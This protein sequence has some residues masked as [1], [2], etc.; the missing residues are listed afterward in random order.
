MISKTNCNWLTPVITAL[1]LAGVIP[2]FPAQ[3]QVSWQQLHGAR[4]AGP[5][6]Q[7]KQKFRN[8]EYK[9][10]NR[11][12]KWQNWNYRQLYTSEINGWSKA[13]QRTS[14]DLE[15]FANQLAVYL[16][17]PRPAVPNSADLKL[18]Q[19]L[20]TMR[21][22]VALLVQNSNRR[23]SMAYWRMQLQELQVLSNR[24]DSLIRTAAP[25]PLVL[26]RWWTVRNDISQWLGLAY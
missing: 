19:D 7:V 8:N 13:Q 18:V 17:M 25:D 20:N 22:R 12:R 23:N 26:Q 2:C 6:Y 5:H 14:K 10:N 24:M 3:A 11:N 4:G 1:V 16:V 15:I 9:Y 21:A